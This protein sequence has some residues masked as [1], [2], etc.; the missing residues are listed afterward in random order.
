MPSVPGFLRRMCAVFYDA[1]LLLAVLFFATAIAL[2]FNGGL[3]FSADQ[4]Y[5]SL[6]LFAITYCFYVWFWVHGETLGLKAWKIK[7]CNLEGDNVNLREATIRFF[8]AILSWGCLGLGFFWC[9]FD[10]NKRSWHDHLSKTQLRL[11]SDEKISS[12]N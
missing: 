2:P 10:R 11:V 4:Y 7:L 1:L 8:A 3:S 6:Y 9:L 5:F 12:P